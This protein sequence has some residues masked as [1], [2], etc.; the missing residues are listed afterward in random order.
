[1]AGYVENAKKMVVIEVANVW[2]G[3]VTTLGCRQA[4]HRELLG[5]LL[6]RQ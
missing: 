5:E 3:R 4:R 1:M 2:Y 6:A